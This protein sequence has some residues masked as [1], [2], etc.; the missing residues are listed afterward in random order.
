M[1]GPRSK[2]RLA[3]ALVVTGIL[4]TVLAYAI[5]YACGSG[6][7]FYE[8]EVTGGEALYVRDFGAEWQCMLY[9]PAARVEALL[10]GYK[11]AL[12]YGDG[13][14]AIV[15]DASDYWWSDPER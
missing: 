11:V 13:T 15:F 2:S 6:L 1:D 8:S 7:T 9:F 4:A 14:R 10:R 3:P 5:G 12:Y